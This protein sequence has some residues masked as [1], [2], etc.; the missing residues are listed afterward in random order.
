MKATEAIWNGTFHNPPIPGGQITWEKPHLVKT[1]DI[2][3]S[4][5]KAWKG[6]SIMKERDTIFPRF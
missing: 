1:G 5:I 3:V 4:N 6:Q 2:L